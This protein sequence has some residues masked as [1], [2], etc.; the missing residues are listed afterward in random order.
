VAAMLEKISS[1]FIVVT[2]GRVAEHLCEWFV[3]KN[4]GAIS[5]DREHRDG[6]SAEHD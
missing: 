1:N 4:N 6:E 5:I 3:S 2:V